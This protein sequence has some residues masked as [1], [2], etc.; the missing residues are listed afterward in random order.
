MMQEAEPALQA[1]TAALALV[2]SA[3]ITEIKNLANPPDDVK[4]VCQ[5]T[6]YFFEVNSKDGSWGNVKAN[7][8]S[9]MKLLVKLKEYDITTCRSDQAKR[10]KDLLAKYKKSTG[11]DGDDLF[12]YV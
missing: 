6:F 7:M 11:L 3:D 8:L 1:A 2:K 9:D 4:T 12:A 5:L 10:A